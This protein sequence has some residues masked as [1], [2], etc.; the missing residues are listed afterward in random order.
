MSS[1]EYESEDEA[2]DFKA[3]PPYGKLAR[4]LEYLGHD[5][6]CTVMKQRLIEERRKKSKSIIHKRFI[7]NIIHTGRPS[8]I[9]RLEKLSNLK[10]HIKELEKEQENENIKVED[11]KKMMAKMKGSDDSIKTN[12]NYL[13]FYSGR[14]ISQSSINKAHSVYKHHIDVFKSKA[15]NIERIQKQVKSENLLV[16]KITDDEEF[17]IGCKLLRNTETHDDTHDNQTK[18]KLN[19]ILDF[20]ILGNTA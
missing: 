19:N 2:P 3:K 13:N 6:Y 20:R 11:V 7:V 10:D 14:Y 16:R 17:G 1:S 9:Q 5:P 15:S 8:E 4:Q 12:Q 18:N